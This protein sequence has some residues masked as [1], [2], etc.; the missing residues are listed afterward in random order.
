MSLFV[1][2]ALC[3]WVNVLHVHSSC[4]IWF[5]APLKDY[6]TRLALPWPAG[7]HCWYE[8]PN[9]SDHQWAHVSDALFLLFIL[10][11]PLLN[12]NS[13]PLLVGLDSIRVDY[14]PRINCVDFI[15]LAQCFPT[16]SCN[17]PGQAGRQAGMFFGWDTY[18]FKVRCEP[19]YPF[20]EGCEVPRY[21]YNGM[22]R[23]CCCNHRHQMRV[24]KEDF[25]S[26][27][28]G[29]SRTIC[30]VLMMLLIPSWVTSFLK[31]VVS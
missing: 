17:P 24:S 30:A 20:K 27:A 2:S 19:T 31:E 26:H 7:V 4:L 5:I 18:P 16:G 10:Y 12:D 9:G 29:G 3:P 15:A 1:W 21:H 13:V 23:F 8:C 22:S 25:Y 28:F 14:D 6:R 11:A